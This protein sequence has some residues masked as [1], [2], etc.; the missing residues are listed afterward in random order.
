M[1]RYADLD[2]CPECVAGKHPNCPGY[3]Y[4][5]DGADQETDCPCASRG[6]R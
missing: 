1:I 4:V 6:H 3:G 5:L 2:P